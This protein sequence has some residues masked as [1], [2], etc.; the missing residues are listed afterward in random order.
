[1]GRLWAA[2]LQKMKKDRKK[3]RRKRIQKEVNRKKGGRFKKAHCSAIQLG[4]QTVHKKEEK[5]EES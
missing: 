2:K 4:L 5:E 1:M 3:E